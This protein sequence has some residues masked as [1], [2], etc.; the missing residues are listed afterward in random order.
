MN[1]WNKITLKNF[2]DTMYTLLHIKHY[3]IIHIV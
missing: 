2:I 3:H 1:F